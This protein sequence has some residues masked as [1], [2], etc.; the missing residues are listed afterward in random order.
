MYSSRTERSLRCALE[1]FVDWL[2]AHLTATPVFL[3]V[4]VFSLQVIWFFILHNTVASSY[5]NWTRTFNA[6]L[7]QNFRTFPTN[8]YN[9]Y[10]HKLSTRLHFQTLKVAL[11]MW[12]LTLQNKAL[13]VNNTSPVLHRLVEFKCVTS[14]GV[15]YQGLSHP[16]S[17]RKLRTSVVRLLLLLTH[18]SPHET[19]ET[20]E[21]SASGTTLMM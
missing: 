5:S 14:M 21:N 2:T 8:F 1:M 4:G 7:F 20:G 19:P 9:L 18:F 16:M 11:Q 3:N 10:Q 6:V 17:R 15:V 13:A 12:N